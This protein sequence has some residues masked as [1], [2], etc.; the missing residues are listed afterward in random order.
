MSRT[1]SGH[2]RAKELY[3]QGYRSAED[4]RKTGEWDKEFRYH[5]NI[6]E[7]IPRAEVESIQEFVR[8][9]L[10]RILPGSHTELCGGSV[11][12]R[13]V[14]SDF[15]RLASERERE[16][17]DRS[18]ATDRYRRGKTMSNDV[19]ILITYPHQD[20]I[21]RGILRKLV[22]R[23]EAKGERALPHLF[24]LSR[25][26][27]L[28]LS[29][30]LAYE[31]RVDPPRRSL[32][33]LGTGDVAHDARQQASVVVRLA[34]QG[35]RHFEAPGERHDAQARLLPSRRFDRRRVG[36]LRRGDRRMDG[37]DPV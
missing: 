3:L 32:V 7:K 9:Q 28:T 22:S 17:A 5:D 15:D 27:F 16:E 30:L 20:G 23:L 37:R 26:R 33:I 2:T 36:K 12:S 11:N 4:L 35:A 24:S 1:S 25:E 34:R 6:V 8:I 10:D 31:I 14:T 29:C 13:P 21:E 19:D 18:G